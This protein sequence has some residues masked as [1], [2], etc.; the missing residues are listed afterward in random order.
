[1]TAGQPSRRLIPQLSKKDD[2]RCQNGPKHFG[3]HQC[4]YTQMDY[5]ALWLWG[6]QITRSNSQ[7]GFNDDSAKRIQLPIPRCICYAA[8]R[9]KNRENWTESYKLNPPRMFNILWRDKFANELAQMNRRDLRLAT[10]ILTG[11]VSQLSKSHC[12]THLPT[13]WSRRRN[14]FP[15]SLADAWETKSRTFTHLLYHSNGHCRQIQPWAENQAIRTLIYDAYDVYT[16]C[17]D[18]ENNLW[19]LHW[20]KPTHHCSWGKACSR[21]LESLIRPLSASSW[22]QV[23]MGELRPQG[24][25]G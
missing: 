23:T 2:S 22:W 6:Q 3:R 7:E 24:G 16:T 15:Y 12:I 5:C 8:L 21:V 18:L 13:L 20:G 14:C 1:M 11:H 9:R 4:G 10:Q 25:G 17:L 19:L